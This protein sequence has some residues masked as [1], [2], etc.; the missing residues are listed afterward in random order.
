MRSLV[1]NWWMMA[2]RGG[3]AAAFGLAV[4]AYPRTS[5][6]R[7]VVMF[8][9][10][11]ILGHFVSEQ[12]GQIAIRLALGATRGEV[13][14]WVLRKGLA[15]TLIRVGIGLVASYPFCN[16]FAEQLFG[17]GP[18]SALARVGAAV[19][20]VAVST[21]AAYLPAARASRVA[22]AEALKSL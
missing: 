7:V 17:L 16:L 10:Y 2:I 11:A 21:V 8:G 14:G 6:W 15:R 22:P 1:R 5:M 13:A 18:N 19:A 4:L 9:V 3:L 20:V 12:R